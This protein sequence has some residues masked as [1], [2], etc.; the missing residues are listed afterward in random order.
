MEK[1][2][3]N[4]DFV[5]EKKVLSRCLVCDVYVHPEESFVCPRCKKAPLCRRHRV[6]G[7]KECASCVFDIRKKELMALNGQETSIKQF[8]RFLQFIF[9]VFA[10][11]FVALKFGLGEYVEL[12][13]EPVLAKYLLY[14]GIIPVLAYILFAALLYNQRGKIADAELQLKKL[15]NRR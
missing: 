3:L 7:R 14:L 4:Q 12:L 10:V 9:L 5:E 2:E 13:R 15:D 11:L 6:P 1:L 8:L